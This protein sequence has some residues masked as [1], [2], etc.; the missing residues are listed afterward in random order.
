LRTE[1]GGHQ[2]EDAEGKGKVK[3]N[4]VKEKGE[5]SGARRLV[6]L[7]ED[8]PKLDEETTCS[9]FEEKEEERVT[10]VNHHEAVIG[11]T[12]KAPFRRRTARRESP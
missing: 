3:R 10:R 11:A 1:A 7:V 5:N 8:R 6:W 12:K 2:G 4:P 9:W